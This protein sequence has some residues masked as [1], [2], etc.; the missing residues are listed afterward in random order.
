MEIVEEALLLE[1]DGFLMLSGTG[2]GVP[3]DIVGFI[4]CGFGGGTSGRLNVFANGAHGFGASGGDLTGI[5]GA[6]FVFAGGFVGGGG[7]ASADLAETTG[8][9]VARVAEA[10]GFVVVSTAPKGPVA[11]LDDDR[12]FGIPPAN[13]PPNAG[14]PVLAVVP[15]VP[16]LWAL[17]LPP[18]PPLP[19]LL[20]T[21]PILGADLSLVVVFFSLVPF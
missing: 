16:V 4:D 17:A 19:E 15:V 7:G 18:E 10:I 11:F 14:G 20:T 12:S 1:R 3:F 5:G 6:V 13:R 9:L 2:G 8:D 21:L